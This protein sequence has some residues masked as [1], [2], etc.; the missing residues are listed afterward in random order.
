MIPEIVYFQTITAC[1]GHCR[2]C[3]FD[4]VYGDREVQSM[5]WEIYESV[6]QWLAGFDYDRRIG[7]L[8]HYEPTLDP[9][10]GKRLE[11]GREILPRARFEVATNGI[12][13]DP[14]L[15]KFDTIDC[16]PAG[17]RIT[18]TSRAGNCRWTP[19]MKNRNKLASGFPC[20]VPVNTFP[21]AANGDVLLCCQDWRHEVVVGTWRDLDG[22]RENQLKLA[23]TDL[24]I[25]RDC[26]AGKTAEEVGDRLGKRHP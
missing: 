23:Q 2:Y 22:A 24:E 25:C 3:P 11:M 17:S 15:D 14:V 26:M 20:P 13:R 7:F 5:S 8:L 4:D 19:E 12:T 1:N 6:L 18:A 10:L 21:V 16:V 9:E